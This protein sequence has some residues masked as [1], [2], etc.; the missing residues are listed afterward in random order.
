MSVKSVHDSSRDFLSLVDTLLVS[1]DNERLKTA[2]DNLAS[3]RA[4]IGRCYYDTIINIGGWLLVGANGK[5]AGGEE[6]LAF[7]KNPIDDGDVENIRVLDGGAVIYRAGFDD[8]YD[9]D[10]GCDSSQEINRILCWVCDQS[11]CDWEDLGG[12]CLSCYVRLVPPS[13][14][15]SDESENECQMQNS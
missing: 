14:I 5:L 13:N 3:A 11:E 6:P 8:H 12:M 10:C 1:Q 7:V 9:E 4:T 15:R 2:V